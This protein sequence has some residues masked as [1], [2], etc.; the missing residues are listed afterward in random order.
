MKV[1]L[2]PSVTLQVGGD[3]LNKL[4]LFEI[5]EFPYWYF[6]RQITDSIILG[7]LGGKHGITLVDYRS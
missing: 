5:E 6:F 3:G 7:R 1:V 2:N 4:N